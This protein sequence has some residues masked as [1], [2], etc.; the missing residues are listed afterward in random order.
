MTFQSVLSL[1]FLGLL[2][3]VARAQTD[4]SVSIISRPLTPITT[5]SSPFFT[6]NGPSSSFDSL[7]TGSSTKPTT[8]IF[9]LSEPTFPP[10][11]T[12]CFIS[13]TGTVRT[14]QVLD[15]EAST[16]PAG[17][18]CVEVIRA[19]G[20]II[21]VELFTVAEDGSTVPASVVAPQ[22]TSGIVSSSSSGSS[23]GTSAIVGAVIGSVFGA[24]LIGATIFWIR[25]Q[26]RSS[27]PVGNWLNRPAGWVRDEKAPPNVIEMSRRDG[28]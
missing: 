24:A 8:T 1:T 5:S 26:R 4:A 11:L 12:T 20:H 19:S 21:E 28:V 25:R 13:P 6:P 22:S 3:S 7:G 23:I 18:E 15:P 14:K 9:G 17:A 16:Q 2:C 27:K 10:T